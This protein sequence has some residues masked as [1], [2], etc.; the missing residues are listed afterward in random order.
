MTTFNVYRR[1][2]NDTNPP[3]AI[4]TGLTSMSYSDDTAEFGKTYLYSVGAVR[5][6]FEKISSEVS[7]S[8]LTTDPYWAN[9]TCLLHFDNSVANLKSYWVWDSGVSFSTDCKVG[10]HSMYT[11]GNNTGMTMDTNAFKPGTGDF[12]V[13]MWVKPTNYSRSYDLSLFGYGTSASNGFVMQLGKSDGRP[14]IWD[15]SNWMGASNTL[16]INTWNHLAFYRKGLEVGCFINGVKNIFN[17]NYTKNISSNSELRILRDYIGATQS[18]YVGYM[19]EFRVTVGVCRYTENF[20]PSIE[21]F[22][23][24]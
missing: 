19:D 18:Y 8:A 11:G 15:G 7:V 6:G 23:N 9:V 14:G 5:S 20:T 4:A 10:T 2:S 16:Q 21:P 24:I 17:S 13:E 22:P 1:E 3:V 12:T